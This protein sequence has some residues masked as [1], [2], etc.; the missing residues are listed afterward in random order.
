MF[1]RAL[2]AFIA[3]PG[4]VAVIIPALLVSHAPWPPPFRPVALLMLVAGVAAL[5]GCVWAFYRDGRGTLAPWA[6]PTTLVTSGLF[7]FS[8]NPMYLAVLLILAGWT[9]AFASWSVGLYAVAV[10]VAFQVRVVRVEEPTLAGAF[11]AAWERYR[12]S[13][14]RW[15]G[16]V[17]PPAGR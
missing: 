5:L 17:R 4:T 2:L 15:L 14:P 9:W 3:L 13:V 8:R 1:L 10:A 11:G 6:P 12:R 7:R 16:A